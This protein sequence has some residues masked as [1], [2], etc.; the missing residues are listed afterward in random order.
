VCELDIALTVVLPR[1]Y[2]ANI[3]RTDAQ[4]KD[5]GFVAIRE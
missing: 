5:Y 3:A 2:V 1:F 4:H